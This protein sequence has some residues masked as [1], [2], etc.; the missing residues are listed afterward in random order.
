MRAGVSLPP[1]RIGDGG[2]RTA[3]L[4]VKENGLEFPSAPSGI[5]RRADERRTDAAAPVETNLD[6][7]GE[8]LRL[9]HELQTAL[10]GGSAWR[11][12]GFSRSLTASTRYRASSAAGLLACASRAR[13]RLCSSLRYRRRLLVPRSPA[14]WRRRGFE[15]GVRL[16]PVIIL[17]ERQSRRTCRMPE[18]DATGTFHRQP[19]L[20]KAPG[21]ELASVVVGLGRKGSCIALPGYRSSQ[22][23][24][25]S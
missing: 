4:S 3:Q 6:F 20:H 21:R 1:C 16:A 14:R 25:L 24:S 2:R 19:V 22:H 17:R 18:R 15:S 23:L 10:R 12:R 13:L 9:E 7:P 5:D 11:R 8:D